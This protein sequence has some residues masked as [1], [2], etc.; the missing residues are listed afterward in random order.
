MA[1]SRSDGEVALFQHEVDHPLQAHAACRHRAKRSCGR[2][3]LQDLGNFIR[4]D[5][6]AAAAEDLHVAASPPSEQIDD[7]LEKLEM[8]ALVA[9]DGNA[10]GVFLYGGIYD[11]GNTACCGPG[12]LPLPRCLAGSDA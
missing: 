10:L 5:D 1:T 8:A 9:T 2:R 6:P 11:L 12:G 3:S 7:I 4:H